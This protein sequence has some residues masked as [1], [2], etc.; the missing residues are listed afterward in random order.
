VRQCGKV[1]GISF[2]DLGDTR[3]DDFA[4]ERFTPVTGGKGSSQSGSNGSGIEDEFDL[5]FDFGLFVVEFSPDDF[6]GG[7]YVTVLELV[8][9]EANHQGAGHV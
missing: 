1:T 6:L 9:E 4:G 5:F 8:L 3:P 7:L 2:Q